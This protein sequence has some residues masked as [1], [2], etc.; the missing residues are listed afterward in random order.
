MVTAMM[1]KAF[2]LIS[3]N[4]GMV[5]HNTVIRSLTKLLTTYYSKTCFRTVQAILLVS[6]WMR[7]L[8]SVTS[9]ACGSYR[10]DKCHDD[11]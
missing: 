2:T 8:D 11:S 3:G 10:S 6:F 7:I 4:A 5:P 9:I 1:T